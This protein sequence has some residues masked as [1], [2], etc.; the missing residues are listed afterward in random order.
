MPSV[1]S[2]QPINQMAAAVQSSSA[3]AGFAL[4]ANAKKYSQEHVASEANVFYNLAL[5]EPMPKGRFSN[6]CLFACADREYT[7]GELVP[8]IVLQAEGYDLDT[9]FMFEDVAR[10]LAL[11]DLIH[12]KAGEPDKSISK[13]ERDILYT[14]AYGWILS[15]TDAWTVGSD[16]AANFTNFLLEYTDFDS[17]NTMRDFIDIVYLPVEFINQKAIPR[18]KEFE[19]GILIND[20]LTLYS[21][22]V[23]R[24]VAKEIAHH[25]RRIRNA[26]DSIQFDDALIMINRLMKEF[27]PE[28]SSRPQSHSEVR[29]YESYWG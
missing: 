8:R 19:M 12:L 2:T 13:M 7:T 25:N 17:V 23:R 22:T 10:C 3:F 29:Y 20:G 15:Q 18:E 26:E 27:A 5:N 16:K 1:F 4:A 21:P 28:D 6:K 9:E 11:L 14:D 24:F